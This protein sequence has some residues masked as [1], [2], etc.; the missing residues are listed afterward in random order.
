MVNAKTK[1]YKL[2]NVQYQE[3]LHHGLH[4]PYTCGVFGKEKADSE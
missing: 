4:F 2:F 3:P 1:V